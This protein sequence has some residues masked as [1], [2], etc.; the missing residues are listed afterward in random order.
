MSTIMI[1]IDKNSNNYLNN[2]NLGDWSVVNAS[3]LFFGFFQSLD[4]DNE[5]FY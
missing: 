3:F 2:L 5:C 4:V 1:E